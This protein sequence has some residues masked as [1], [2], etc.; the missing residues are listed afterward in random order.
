MEPY[1]VFWVF[2]LQFGDSRCWIFKKYTQSLESYNEKSGN[3]ETMTA[4]L[5]LGTDV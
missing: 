1:E 3:A 4:D 2:I 5:L